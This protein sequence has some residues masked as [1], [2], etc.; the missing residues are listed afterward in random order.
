MRYLL[1]GSCLLLLAG[2]ASVYKG[3]QPA[4]GDIN[5]LQKFRPDQQRVLY[6][7]NIDVT[8]HHLS[9][10][11]LLKTLPDS[12]IR[13]VFSSE[14]G[15]KF[16]DFEY[17][18][19]GGF[20]V[21][22]IIKQMDKGP[23]KKTLKKDIELILF[24]PKNVK[25]FYLLKDSGQLYYIFPRP[26]GTYCYITDLQGSRLVRMEICSPRRPI[27]EATLQK[28]EDGNT[29]SISIKHNNFPFTIGLKKIE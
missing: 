14:M 19:D 4:T 5:N 7:A 27:V 11:L 9:G 26:K 10:L 17:K 24:P 1:L 8:G 13:A 18:P 22:S 25:N 28:S 29:D 6:K 12:S 16:F 20:K 23:V 2:C 21:Y 15:V 3:L